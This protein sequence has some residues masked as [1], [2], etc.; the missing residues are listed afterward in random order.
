VRLPNARPPWLVVDRHIE[1]VI[2]GSHWPGKLWRVR[3]ATLGD[4]S[5]LLPDAHY[6]RAS[7]IELLEPLPLSALFG[8]HG[9][10]VVALLERVAALTNAQAQRLADCISNDAARVYSEAWRRWLLE[11][12]PTSIHAASDL[13]D[14]IA[15]PSPTHRARSPINGGFSLVY[16]HVRRRASE[17]D[18]DDALIV[19]TDEW[20][21]SETALAQPWSSAASAALHAAFALA[22]PHDTTLAERSELL[23][24][25]RSVFPEDCDVKEYDSRGDIEA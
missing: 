10:H 5:G 15:I 21:E 16:D 11:T 20:G 6:W 19:E 8:P 17:V 12:D 2:V 13:S 4:M 23:R 24:A 3:V 7:E 9:A 18:G 14:T 25:W 22:A 1:S